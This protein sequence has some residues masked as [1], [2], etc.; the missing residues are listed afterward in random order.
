M[1]EEKGELFKKVM[2]VRDEH[3]NREREI[4]KQ[5]DR[6]K[7]LNRLEE[8]INDLQGK[9]DRLEDMLL[10]VV[11]YIDQQENTQG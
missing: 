5:K 8:R 10:T 9:V 11:D 7:E 4:N 6:M 3:F 1:P 2:N